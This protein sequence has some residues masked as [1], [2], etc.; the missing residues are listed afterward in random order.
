MPDELMGDLIKEAQ[1]YLTQLNTLEVASQLTLEDFKVFKE[2][3]DTEYIDEIFGLDSKYGCPNLQKFAEVSFR[4]VLTFCILM[5]FPIHIDAIGLGLPILYFKGPQVEVSELLFFL[6]LKVDVLILAN[7]ADSG[8]MQH[9][10]AF[11]LGLHCLPKYPFRDLQF[12]K[13]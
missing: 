7:S 11:H 9:Y 10:A 1:I 12:R 5:D 13:G 6:S 4:E 3:Q 2:I 8:E